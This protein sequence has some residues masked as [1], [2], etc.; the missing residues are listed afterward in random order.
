MPRFATFAPKPL[1]AVS[2][3]FSDTATAGWTQKAMGMFLDLSVGVQVPSKP[4]HHGGKTGQWRLRRAQSVLH[5][6]DRRSSTPGGGASGGERGGRRGGEGTA[7]LRCQ[8]GHHGYSLGVSAEHPN[9][10][11]SSS[12]TAAKQIEPEA[13]ASA[14]RSKKTFVSESTEFAAEAAATPTQ[15]FGK[16]ITAILLPTFVGKGSGAEVNHSA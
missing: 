3:G 13:K 7:A 9:A 16:N 5:G 4:T 8:P 6:G 14:R 15:A 1:C 2:G 12:G 10:P 11:E